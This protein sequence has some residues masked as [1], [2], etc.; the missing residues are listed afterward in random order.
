MNLQG[1]T[2][3]SCKT[4]FKIDANPGLA[5][6]CFE[7]PGPDVFQTNRDRW[8][9]W[10][11]TRW[12]GKGG[13]GGGGLKFISSLACISR[14]FST[15][16]KVRETWTEITVFAWSCRTL[17]LIKLRVREGEDKWEGRETLLFTLQ[18]F[19]CFSR[20]RK[21][22]DCFASRYTPSLRLSRLETRLE[23]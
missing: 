11:F 6:P 5:W 20:T 19:V 1:S 8:M 7:Q 10:Y 4:E 22:N 16:G 9:W 15:S 14:F 3:L 2:S 13:G 17:P 18:A 12:W 21:G 23:F